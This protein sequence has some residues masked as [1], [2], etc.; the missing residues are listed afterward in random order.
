MCVVH[1]GGLNILPY[2]AY[3]SYSCSLLLFVVYVYCVCL[4]CKYTREI[5]MVRCGCV[6]ELCNYIVYCVCSMLLRVM[7]TGV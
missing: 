6:S 3:V 7:V 4:L 1:T 5:S 2:S